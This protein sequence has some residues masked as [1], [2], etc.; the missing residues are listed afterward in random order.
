MNELA[1]I[2]GV[3]LEEP[4]L[5]LELELLLAVGVPLLQA[6]S[7]RPAVTASVPVQLILVNGFKQIT[8]PLRGSQRGRDLAPFRTAVAAPWF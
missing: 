2:D 1:E 7:A 8:S 5:G 6:A 4:E 3:P